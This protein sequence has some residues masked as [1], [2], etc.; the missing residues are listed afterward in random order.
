M[1]KPQVEYVSSLEIKHLFIF[2]PVLARLSDIDFGGIH[3]EIQE[4]ETRQL[5]PPIRVIG[6]R[7]PDSKCVFIVL[8]VIVSR[9][10]IL[11][12]PLELS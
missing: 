2:V 11:S 6:V 4:I 12:T 8:R 10:H 3:K 5:F 9:D 1:R 7:P